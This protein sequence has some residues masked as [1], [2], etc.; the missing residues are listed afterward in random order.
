[1]L[2]KLDTIFIVKSIK[3]DEKKS[4]K[5]S[6]P[7]ESQCM[8]KAGVCEFYEYGLGVY[9]LNSIYRIDLE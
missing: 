6:I 5:R 1:M 9:Y 2:V 8:L 4:N 7:E 3:C